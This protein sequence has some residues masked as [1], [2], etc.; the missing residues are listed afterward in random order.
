MEATAIKYGAALLLI[1]AIVAWFAV[2]WEKHNAAEQQLGQVQCIR[3]TTSAGDV[4]VKQTAAD[5]VSDATILQK[6]VN[7]YDQK[8]RD[9]SSSNTDLA[10]RLH[11][12]HAAAAKLRSSAVPAVPGSAGQIRTAADDSAPTDDDRR[13]AE[14]LEACAANTIELTEI[15][16]A[17]IDLAKSRKQ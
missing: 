9:L 14:D 13:E 16:A 10:Q 2:Q 15:R 11:D 17:W 5:T 7:E 12:E 1:S 8:I 3:D 6:V 4:Q